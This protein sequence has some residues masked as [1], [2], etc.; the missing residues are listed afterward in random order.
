M[1]QTIRTFIAIPLNTEIQQA[2]SRVQERLKKHDCSIKWVKPENIHLTLKFLGDVELE[3]IDTIK[4]KLESLFKGIGPVKLEMTQLDAFPSIN[5]P[6]IL[7]IGLK[8]DEQ[9]ISRQVSVL[10]DE[11]G[12]LG[13]KKEERPFSP[14][15]TIGRIRSPRNIQ[16]LSEAMSEYSFPAGLKQVIDCIILYKSTLTSQGPI[17][18]SLHETKLSWKVP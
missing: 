11:L 14:H 1:S 8:D 18:E 15:V 9:K 17:Y 13:F 4:Q 5:H 6:K 16:A 2:I 7:W 10:E 3:K 12:K